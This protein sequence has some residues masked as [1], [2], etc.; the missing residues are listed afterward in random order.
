MNLALEASLVAWKE[1]HGCLHQKLLLVIGGLNATYIY[2]LN[3]SAVDYLYEMGFCWTILLSEY[4]IHGTFLLSSR[5][6]GFQSHPQ[7]RDNICIWIIP[8]TENISSSLHILYL[9]PDLIIYA[10]KGAHWGRLYYPYCCEKCILMQTWLSPSQ[11]DI[12]YFTAVDGE[13]QSVQLN[14]QIYALLAD[15]LGP[16]SVDKQL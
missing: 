2:R 9:L 6:I 15:S 14:F 3:I 13:F 4:W 8:L 10:M 1:R 16:T 7:Q 12:S 11:S 5:Y